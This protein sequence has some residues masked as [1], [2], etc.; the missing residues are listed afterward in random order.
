MNAFDAWAIAH[1]LLNALA[2]VVVIAAVAGGL[3]AVLWERKPPDDDS[4]GPDSWGI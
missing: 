2:T 1:P 4:N 3:T